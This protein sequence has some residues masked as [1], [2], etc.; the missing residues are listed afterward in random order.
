MKYF[1]LTTGLG[2]G[3]F[4]GEASF[5]N[6]LGYIYDEFKERPRSSNNYS[7]GGTPS[8]DK[9]FRGDA[10][11][12][13]GLEW[14]IPHINGSKFKIEYDPFDYFDFSSANRPDALES[15]RAKDSNI[16]YGIS[17]PIKNYGNFDFSFVKGNTFNITFSI[18][19]TFN[20]D[21]VKKSKI[22]P[23]I[24]KYR[25]KGNKN[26]FYEDLLINMNKN[27]FFLQT[28][29]LKESEIISAIS[30]PQHRNHIRSASYSGYIVK[31][32][33][34]NHD[35]IL[36]EIKIVHLNAGLELNNISLRP[37]DVDINKSK[38]IELIRYYSVL[39]SGNANN[40]LKS[41][42]KP[43][44]PL[45]AFF[46]ETGLTVI[47]HIGAPEQFYFGGVVLQNSTEVLLKRNL[48]LTSEINLIL[49]DNFRPTISGSNSVLPHVRTDIMTY[50]I[51]GDKSITK[52]QLDYIWSPGKDMY[53]KISGGIFEK[54]YGGFGGEFLYKPFD[55]NIYVGFE[56]FWVKKRGF[57]QRLRFLDYS[58]V[59]SH[60]N[61]NYLFPR[62]G[63]NSKISFGKYL[64]KDTGF[65]VDISRTT[66]DG[67][68]AGI[69]FTR[70]NVSAEDFGEG[71]FDKG[72][73]FEIPFDLF[74]KKYSGK[75]TNLKLSPLTR[76]GGQKL[77]YSKD[78][79][80]LIHNSTSFEL[81]NKWD[82]FLN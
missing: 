18:G 12:F 77:I 9:W 19:A 6:P 27:N 51:D 82:G 7:Q 67:F 36:D 34:K 40:F 39:E 46:S 33:A 38:Q 2:W 81:N 45:P 32:V 24:K 70:T 59:T 15:I 71:S 65:T 26:N 50:L 8:Y 10:S 41:E 47:N 61:F 58:T 13:G 69:Y 62:S 79:I 3:K 54:M 37:K 44:L 78:L 80:G 66:N 29:T 20:N 17:I 22:E 21:L 72:F 14:F 31:E 76:D 23:E 73:Y 75:H 4:A 28:S 56:S 52:L 55:S 1:K 53:S 64:A 35:I 57:D 49:K 48:I 42:Y 25:D 5:N 43:D 30:V 68:K 60:I 63:I 74:S 16:N 11:F